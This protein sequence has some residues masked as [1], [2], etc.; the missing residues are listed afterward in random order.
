MKKLVLNV[1]SGAPANERLYPVFRTSEW[2]ETRLDLDA[3]VTPDILGSI[4]ELDRLVTSRH[5]DAVWSSHSLEHLDSHEV[6]DALS[7][8]RRALKPTGFALV[9]CPDLMAIARLVIDGG[10]EDVAY[11]SSMGPIRPLDMLYGHSA[12]IEAGRKYM[13]H[14]TGFTQ[15]RLGRAAVAAGFAETVVLE[16]ENFD[17]WAICLM[18]EAN[19]SWLSK[20]FAGSNIEPLIRAAA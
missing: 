15:E 13:A 1:G 4:T 19:K 12:S 6:V 2:S 5:F 17:L 11:V 10:I 7:S 9:T 8:F 16:G 14:K 18:P 3:T 20:V